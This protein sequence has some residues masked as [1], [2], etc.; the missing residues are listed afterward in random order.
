MI[1]I[2]AGTKQRSFSYQEYVDYVEQLYNEGKATGSEQS[3]DRLQATKLNLSRI[4]RL[5]K[6]I[7][8]DLDLIKLIKSVQSKWDW[9]LILEGWCGDGAQ[10]APYINKISEV[11]PQ[12]NLKIVLRDENPELMDNH[13][14]NG[15][16]SIPVLICVDTESQEEIGYW[17][18]RPKAVLNW[19]QEFKTEHPEYTSEEFKKGLHSF[20]TKDKGA[21]ICADLFQVISSWKNDD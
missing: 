9:I 21:S 4:H 10:I 3:S 20:Y 19:V 18:P 13:L 14:T 16:R 15:T 5:N 1:L 17:G 2:G 6:T 12:I 7:Q 11:N 8:L